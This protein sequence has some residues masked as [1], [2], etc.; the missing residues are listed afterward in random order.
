M[1]SLL[2]MHLLVLS[3]EVIELDDGGDPIIHIL[4]GTEVLFHFK[5]LF[6]QLYNYALYNIVRDFF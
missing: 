4:K 5:Y 3:F 2:S 1:S 6:F